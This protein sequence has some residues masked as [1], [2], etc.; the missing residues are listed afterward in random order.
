[1]FMILNPGGKGVVI[2][3]VID[4]MS[5]TTGIWMEGYEEPW[6]RGDSIIGTWGITVNH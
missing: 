4:S 3:N 1:M 6:T 5:S 2:E